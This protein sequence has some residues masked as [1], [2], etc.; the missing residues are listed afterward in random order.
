M[1]QA[2][3]QG[4]VRSLSGFI[5]Q[6]PNAVATIPSTTSAITLD[7]TY[8][9]KVI[10]VTPATSGTTI[11]LPALNATAN[12]TSSGPGQDPNTANNLGTSYTFFIASTPPTTSDF[13]KIITGAGNFLLGEIVVGIGATTPAGSIVMYAADGTSTRSVN[14]N[15]TTKGGIAGTFVTVTAVTATTFMVYGKAIGSG[16]LATPFATS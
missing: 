9:G 15:G 14:F 8:I 13:V 3:F 5:S 1:A 7:S 10:S 4:P 11:T 16:T 12:P 2:T 6:G